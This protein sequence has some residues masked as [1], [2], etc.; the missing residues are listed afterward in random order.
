MHGELIVGRRLKV[1]LCDYKRSVFTLSRSRIIPIDAH[2]IRTDADSHRDKETGEIDMAFFMQQNSSLMQQNSSTSVKDS[3]MLNV[4]TIQKGVDQNAA[5]N[6][7]SVK[8]RKA[9]R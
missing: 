1:V 2:R 7:D 5:S 8:A 6:A 9:A 4:S 3:S